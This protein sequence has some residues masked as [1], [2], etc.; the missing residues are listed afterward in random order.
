MLNSFLILKEHVWVLLLDFN[1]GRAVRA[2]WGLYHSRSEDLTVTLE[3]SQDNRSIWTLTHL[4][5]SLSLRS[6]RFIVWM[7]E[8]R[9][10]GN[11]R[12]MLFISRE[13]KIQR[14]SLCVC[15]CVLCDGGLWEFTESKS[16][17]GFLSYYKSVQD[18]VEMVSIS[19]QF[20]CYETF[21]MFDLVIFYYWQ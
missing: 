3:R 10:G 19:F 18:I 1:E 20:F 4:E 2:P 14:G 21:G 5:S 9:A 13:L 16:S 15:A 12:Q 11:E 7:T 8:G 6:E 17:W